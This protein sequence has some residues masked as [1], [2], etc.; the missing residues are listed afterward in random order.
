MHLVLPRYQDIVPCSKATRT[1][2]RL[3]AYSCIILIVVAIALFVFILTFALKSAQT[4]PEPSAARLLPVEEEMTISHTP[5]IM[6]ASSASTTTATILTST[7]S[8]AASTTFSTTSSTTA[9]PYTNATGAYY[10]MPT[11]SSSNFDATNTIL[12]T[13]ST[14][15]T[16][17]ANATGAYYS[18]PT[19]S[20]SDF[21]ATTT[22]LPYTTTYATSPTKITQTSS[23]LLPS[24]IQ[25][26]LPTQEIRENTYRLSGG[27]GMIA[28]SLMGMATFGG[29]FFLYK[30]WKEHKNLQ[31]LIDIESIV[32]RNINERIRYQKQHQ[33]EIKEKQANE[34]NEL[35]NEKKAS[36]EKHNTLLESIRIAN[37]KLQQ[38]QSAYTALIVQYQEVMEEFMF[39]SGKV[40]IGRTNIAA[41]KPRIVQEE[42]KLKTSSIA[43]LKRSDHLVKLDKEVSTMQNLWHDQLIKTIISVLLWH[44]LAITSS[45][46]K[47]KKALIF[48]KDVSINVMISCAFDWFK[49]GG[50]ITSQTRSWFTIPAAPKITTILNKAGPSVSIVGDKMIQENMRLTHVV[51]TSVIARK[52]SWVRPAINAVTNRF[53]RML[54]S[55]EKINIAVVKTNTL[56]QE[57]GSWDEQEVLAITRT[58]PNVNDITGWVAENKHEKIYEQCLLEI[59]KRIG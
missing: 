25:S 44:K 16:S 38:L 8:T 58:I 29:G 3:C 2:R 50:Y 43:L 45:S 28:G 13:T 32:E 20:S 1:K 24:S 9:T 37:V 15:T 14:T 27:R 12:S 41:I 48:I 6:A 54:T 10:S 53:G 35:Q 22:A 47:A 34:M 5:T 46:G 7:T 52:E 31:H 33:S 51:T 56:L 30:A 36:K 57:L 18:M 21:H 49:V 17:A 26:V 23:T 19:L 59:K 40:A 39:Y 55:E 11:L 42:H 4:I